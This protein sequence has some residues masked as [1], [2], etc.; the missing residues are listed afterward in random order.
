TS[1]FR[2]PAR[3]PGAWRRG[4]GVR[5]GLVPQDPGAGLDP[6]VRVGEQVAEAL[7][8][9]G[10]PR[11]DARRRAVE[12]LGAVGLDHPELR[13]RQYPH[14]LSGGMRQR[15]LVGIATAC[16]PRLVIADEPTSALDV[17]VQRRVL[18]LLADLTSRTGTAVL[19]I[20][21]DLAVA[22]HR[23]D[24]VVVLKDGRVVEE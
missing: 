24:R 3:R 12:I 2:P 11:R 1:L 8:V 17:T 15:V 19:L 9:H 7:V 22:A 14:Q 18:D 21:H 13:A 23:A 6:V 5:I 20:T 16:E 10:T 4:R